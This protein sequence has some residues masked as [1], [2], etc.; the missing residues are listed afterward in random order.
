VG[1]GHRSVGEAGLG[2]TVQVFGAGE[3]PGDAA[4]VGAAF[5]AVGGGEVVLG[6]DVGDADTAA[7][8]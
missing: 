1:E 8:C 7:R 2:Q 4:D 5:G 6:D 3:G